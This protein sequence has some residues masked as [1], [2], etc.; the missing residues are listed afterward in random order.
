MVLKAHWFLVVCVAPNS[1]GYSALY[2]LMLA[3]CE[4]ILVMSGCRWV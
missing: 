2:T 4:G 1:A 3:A